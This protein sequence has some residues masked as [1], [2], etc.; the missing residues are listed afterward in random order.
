MLSSNHSDLIEPA[1]KELS[2]R[3]SPL[4]RIF[5]S[6]RTTMVIGRA[7]CAEIEAEKPVRAKSRIG[8]TVRIKA[9]QSESEGQR[10]FSLPSHKN[11]TVRLNSTARVKTLGRQVSPF[12][13]AALF[14][15]PSSFSGRTKVQRQSSQ[16]DDDPVL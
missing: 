14:S 16:A 11:L 4:T 9:E 2:R 10:Y 5:P 6:D 8:A 13:R 15:E 1:G 3:T 7:F 12:R